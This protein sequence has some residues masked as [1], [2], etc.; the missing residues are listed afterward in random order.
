MAMDYVLRVELG[1]YEIRGSEA[2]GILEAGYTG[3]EIDVEKGYPLARQWLESYETSREC[4]LDI[5]THFLT[6]LASA[7]EG[8]LDGPLFRGRPLKEPPNSDFDF[9]PPPPEKTPQNRYN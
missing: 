2:R 7:R 3:R 8:T 6:S 1:A 9:G 5:E 4:P